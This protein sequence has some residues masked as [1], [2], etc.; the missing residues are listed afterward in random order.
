M[1]I[2]RKDQIIKSNLVKYVKSEKDILKTMRH[3]FIVKLKYS[4]QTDTK[5]FMVMQFCK[6]QLI[7]R[8]LRR[9]S[10]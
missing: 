10:F 8:R 1:K 3:P 5:L 2:L 7:I 4:F 6:F 9:G